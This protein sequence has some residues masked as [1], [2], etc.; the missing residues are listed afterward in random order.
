[1]KITLKSNMEKILKELTSIET[2]KFPKRKQEL[3]RDVAQAGFKQVVDKYIVKG[4]Y[5]KGQEYITPPGANIA[6]NKVVAYNPKTKWRKTKRIPMFVRGKVVDRHGKYLQQMQALSQ[7]NFQ[8]RVEDISVKITPDK[9][10]ILADNNS[11]TWF[12][13]KRPQAGKTP[14]R[15]IFRA[16]RSVANIWKKYIKKGKIL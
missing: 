3:L 10:Q 8:E 1:M 9:I 12:I 11:E 16:F 13:E 14:I 2:K 15:P 4:N 5:T 6:A 7:S